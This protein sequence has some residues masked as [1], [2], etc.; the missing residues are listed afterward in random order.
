MIPFLT[1]VSLSL[2]AVDPAAIQLGRADKWRNWWHGDIRGTQHRRFAR[3]FPAA[4]KH[5]LLQPVNNLF[6]AII[7]NNHRT[8]GLS[9]LGKKLEQSTILEMFLEGHFKNEARCG[10]HSGIFEVDLI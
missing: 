7:I 10:P 8:H 2:V 4:R 5:I 6:E 9:S 3:S 1:I